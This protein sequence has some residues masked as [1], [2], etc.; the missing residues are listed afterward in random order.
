MNKKGSGTGHSGAAIA[1]AFIGTVVGAGF[2]SGQ[3]TLQFFTA[4][5]RWGMAGLGVAT[6]LFGL[7]GA[8]MLHVGRRLGATSHRPLIVHALGPRLAPVAD[9]LLTVFLLATAGAMAAGAASTLAEQYGLARWVGSGL[10]AVVSGATVLTGING[11][12]TAIALIAP[13]LILSILG[14]ALYSLS[15]GGGLGAAWAWQGMTELAPIGPWW[16]AA[17]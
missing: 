3:E 12:V 10:M 5:G 15:L 6:L 11:V 2:A 17:G 14:I 1:G 8:R 4:F 16:V 13:L 7:V 9:G